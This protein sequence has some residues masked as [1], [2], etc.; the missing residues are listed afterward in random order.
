VHTIDLEGHGTSALKGQPLRMENFTEN[1]LDYLNH[2]TIE[3]IRIFAQ[4]LVGHVGLYITRFLP[5]RAKTMFALETKYIWIPDIAGKENTF[6]I[7]KK[8]AEKITR[9]GRMLK[10]RNVTVPGK[11]LL[12]KFREILVPIGH[13]NPPPQGEISVISQK[14]RIGVWGQRRNHRS[15]G[16][17][18]DLWTSSEE[19]TSGILR[20]APYVG[21]GV[22]EESG[23][24]GSGFILANQP[25]TQSR[26]FL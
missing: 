1:V 15:G 16:Q 19:Q 9:F 8:L 21:K 14:V 4:S 20:H 12:E 10:E 2:R 13:R 5:D 17:P 22:D 25:I 7:P 18:A 23:N 26:Y 3:L 6:L 24:F 11:I